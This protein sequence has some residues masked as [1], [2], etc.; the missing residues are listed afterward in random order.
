MEFS[1][2]LSNKRVIIVGPSSSLV[3]KGMG[4]FIDS[5]DVVCRIK[6]S[7][8]VPKEYE[9]DL[10]KRTDILISHLKLKSK[11]YL[12]NNFK[13][14]KS[15]IYNKNLRYIYFPFP[16]YEHFEKFYKNFK[17]DCNDIR[18][19]VI[20]QRNTKNLEL[21]KKEL[22][23][24]YPTTGIAAIKGLLDYNIKELYI[25]GMTFQKDGFL[26]YYKTDKERVACMERTKHIHNLNNEL[27]YFKKLF[28]E[29]Q[30]KIKI[31]EELKNIL[32]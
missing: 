10:G 31:N 11:G 27:I 14:H 32:K 6:K 1:N 4:K 30:N 26:D 28:L 18:V 25:I 29:N 19:P 9:N 15:N 16:L 7:F 2:F 23:N 5:F 21:L 12:Q 24:S 13:I 17:T 3:N 22:K 8:P 20:Y